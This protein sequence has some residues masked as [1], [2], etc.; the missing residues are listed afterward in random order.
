M[1]CGIEQNVRTVAKYYT[2][3]T[4]TRLSELLDLST[5]ETEETLARLAVAKMVFAKI[6]RPA[7]VVSFVEPKS[8]DRVLNEWSS[9][10]NKLMV[11][12]R[13]DFEIQSSFSLSFWRTGLDRK[14][15]ASDRKRASRRSSQS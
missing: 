9:D 15:V 11:R 10:V 2:R 8:T 13:P 6:D 4:L 14:D 5:R 1:I 12:W 7:G 3:I